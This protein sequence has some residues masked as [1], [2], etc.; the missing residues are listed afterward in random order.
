MALFDLM[1]QM[2]SNLD[3]R[4]SFLGRVERRF[5]DALVAYCHL[6]CSLT[7]AR[8]AGYHPGSGN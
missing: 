1:S 7:F 5:Y 8:F 4:R 2:G 6:A 3:K